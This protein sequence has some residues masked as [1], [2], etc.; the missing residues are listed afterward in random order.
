MKQ[1]L[2]LC[3]MGWVAGCAQPTP[4]AAVSAPNRAPI[5]LDGVSRSDESLG[6]E[7]R[8]RLSAEGPE[9]SSVVAT[10]RGGVVSLNGSVNSVRAAYRAEAAARAVQGVTTVQNALIV[11]STNQ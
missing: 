10:V 6:A 4:P 1:L 11:H 2:V 5:S 7:V 9:L 8:R 3:L